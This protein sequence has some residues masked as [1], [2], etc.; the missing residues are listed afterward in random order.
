MNETLTP[1]EKAE[2]AKAI[3][4]D[5]IYNDDELRPALQGL[6]AKKFP[7]AKAEMPDFVA[8]EEFGK[9]RESFSKER[10]EWR[11]ERE[12]DKN[13]RD[14][15]DRRARLVSG[16][17]GMDG[18]RL[19]VEPS[20]IEAVEKLMME[21]GIASHERAAELYLASRRVAAPVT[22]SHRNAE[23]PGV[24]GAGGAEYEWL[25]PGVA[26]DRTTLDRVARAEAER[27]WADIKSGRGDK[28]IQTY[29]G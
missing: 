28:W 19:R 25:K 13:E 22:Y 17:T 11:K 5:G 23:V 18:A 14:L 2:R 4:L 24:G 8:R 27:V 3:L 15:R 10:D 26:G 7:K 29:G 16:F 9:E 6:I 1:E 12:R 20:D 21:E